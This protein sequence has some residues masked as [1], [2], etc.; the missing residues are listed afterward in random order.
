MLLYFKGCHREILQLD[1]KVCG[2]YHPLK[3]NQPLYNKALKLRG[4]P[5]RDFAIGF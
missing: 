1:C 3:Y 4:L 5:K 2:Q